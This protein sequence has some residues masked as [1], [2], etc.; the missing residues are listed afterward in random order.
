MGRKKI[1]H[2]EE[3]RIARFNYTRTKAGRVG[4]R[5]V[6]ASKSV[7][8]VRDMVGDICRVKGAMYQVDLKDVYIRAVMGSEQLLDRLYFYAQQHNGE[9]KP[10][11]AV[12]QQL[13]NEMQF[14]DWLVDK[15]NDID[16]AEYQAMVQYFGDAKEPTKPVRH[17]GRYTKA[18]RLNIEKWNW[19]HPEDPFYTRVVIPKPKIR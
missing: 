9:Y 12:I 7:E 19:F 6:S 8:S 15:L 2:T 14:H 3:E 16:L 5:F 13:A 18:E 11:S 4:E 1:S 17:G 10:T